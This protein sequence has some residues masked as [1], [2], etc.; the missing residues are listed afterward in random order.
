[1]PGKLGGSLGRLGQLT[2]AGTNNLEHNSP[3]N[4]PDWISTEDLSG[5]LLTEDNNQLTTEG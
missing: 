5:I 1:M 3:I 2:D 4:T